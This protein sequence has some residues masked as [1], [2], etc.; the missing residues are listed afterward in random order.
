[1]TLAALFAVVAALGAW[2]Y[3]KPEPAPA[4]TYALS[5]LKPA[6]VKRLRLERSVT[7]QEDRA[8]ATETVALEKRNGEWRMV[9]P[10]AARAEAFP[11]DR[12]LAILEARSTA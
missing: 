8:G 1:M 11:V 2:I 7:P 5:A 12:A 10:I 6:D 4:E 9:K 3:V